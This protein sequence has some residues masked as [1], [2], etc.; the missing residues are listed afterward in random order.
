MTGRGDEPVG[1]EWTLYAVG[2]LACASLPAV[3]PALAVP[4][5]LHEVRTGADAARSGAALATRCAVV[6]LDGR[7]VRARTLAGT[8]VPFLRNRTVFPVVVALDVLPAL[9][10]EWPIARLRAL[11]AELR[12]CVLRGASAPA[13]VPAVALVNAVVEPLY[14]P[15]ILC[16]DGDDAAAVLAPPA[17]AL[18]H[19]WTPTLLGRNVRL[20]AA[21]RA[22]LLEDGVRSVHAHFRA[23]PD[24]NPLRRID[25][26]LRSLVHQLDGRAV[27]LLASGV[28][29]AAPDDTA[30]V[31]VARG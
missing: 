6:L 4:P 30:L 8:L 19:A 5:A 9:A 11:A 2:E 27:D 3:L 28:D 14:A 7:D 16:F 10:R 23:S 21:I 1:A 17:C 12:A 26:A 18:V 13:S 15:G 24:G 20:P 31:L 25:A 29:C 22:D